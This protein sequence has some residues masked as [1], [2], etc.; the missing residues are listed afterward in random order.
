V[1]GLEED[2]RVDS[3]WFATESRD[4]PFSSIGA[5]LWRRQF[6]DLVHRNILSH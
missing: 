5:R 2:R 6:N 4:F 3:V 1:G